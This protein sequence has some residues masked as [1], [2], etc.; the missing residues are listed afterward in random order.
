MIREDISSSARRHP[1]VRGGTRATV[2]S[3]RLYGFADRVG[4]MFTE[5]VQSAAYSARISKMKKNL[6]LLSPIS[7]FSAGFL[8]S[9]SWRVVYSGGPTRIW[10]VG[11]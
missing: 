6:S 9:T 11:K 4:D 7:T 3:R 2:P 5:Q 8:V 1:M 10:L